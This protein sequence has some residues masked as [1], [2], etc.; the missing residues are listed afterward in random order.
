[1]VSAMAARQFAPGSGRPGRSAQASGVPGDLRRA[2]EA[3]AAARAAFAALPP[4]HRRAYVEWIEEAKRPETRARRVAG[5]VERLRQSGL[6][7]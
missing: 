6:A 2:L 3:D 5:A 1:M 4:S 7:S